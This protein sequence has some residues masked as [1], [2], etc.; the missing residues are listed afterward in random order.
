MSEVKPNRRA[1]VVGL[2]LIGGSFA[3][4]WKAAGW[5]VLAFDTDPETLEAA[6]VETIEGVLDEK[7]IASCDII[8]LAAYPKACVGWLCEHAEMLG[9]LGEACPVIID[10]AGTKRQI[11]QKAFPLA[12]RHGFPFCGTHP[13]AGTEKTGFANSRQDLFLGAPMVLVPPTLSDEDR[14]ELLDRVHELLEPIGFGSYSVSTPEEHD[15]TIAF[16]SQ[17]A[18]VVSNAYIKSPTAR[19]HRGF[20]AGSYKDLTRVARLNAPMW[21]ELMLENSENLQREIDALIAH[22]GQYQDVLIRHDGEAL[23]ALLAEGDRIK[24]A[25]D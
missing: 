9:D 18:H 6:G 17:L 7:A 4:A 23:E 11:C 10:A 12:E 5:S 21:R 19:A 14:L 16:T 15:R 13:M 1:G 20:S 24:R 3:R 22:L 25:L 2:G 8:V